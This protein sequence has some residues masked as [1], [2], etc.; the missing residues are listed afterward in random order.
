MLGQSITASRLWSWEGSWILNKSSKMLSSCFLFFALFLS[1]S[2]ADWSCARLPPPCCGLTT[3][4]GCKKSRLKKKKKVF[5]IW[6]RFYLY[7]LFYLNYFY[8]AVICWLT[9]TIFFSNMRPF[10]CLEIVHCLNE[11]IVWYTSP[12]LSFYIKII[13]RNNSLIRSEI[14]K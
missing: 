2:H 13:S 8:F 4:Q 12:K 9:L 1:Y 6:I 7:Q 10:S 11:T 3:Q 14:Q 5:Y